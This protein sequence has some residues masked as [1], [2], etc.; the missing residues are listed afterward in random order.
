MTDNRIDKPDMLRV[1]FDALPSRVF[2][3]DD[4]VRIQEYNSAAAY[5]LMAD[6]KTVL[7]KRAGDILHCV[8]SV[9]VPEGCGR[10]PAC[11]T[12]IIRNSVSEA[13][14]GNRIVRRRARI[15]LISN[16]HQTEIYA[17]ITASPFSF[18]EKLH[19]L[20]VIEDISEIAE[21]QRLIPIC[22]VCRKLRDDKEA[23][24]GVETYFKNSWDVDFTH[25]YCPDCFKIEMDK[26]KAAKIAKQGSQN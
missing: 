11:K 6:R 7:K 9:E 18:Q 19:A 22:C 21:L 23:W 3:V 2:V 26:V 20:L 4:D 15:A 24:M 8:H 1:V 13:F 17:L 14:Q 16:E 25:G 10:A 5:L 12:C